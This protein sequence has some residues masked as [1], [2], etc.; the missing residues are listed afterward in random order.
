[1]QTAEGLLDI[2]ERCH[3]NLIGLLEHCTALS[4]DQLNQELPGFGYP[5]LRLQ[6]HHELGA[7][8]YWIGVLA[9]KMIIDD[10]EAL[11][12]TI[13]TLQSMRES[14]AATTVEYLRG[15][16]VEELNTPRTLLTWGN[17]ERSLQPAHVV[18]RTQMH[19]YHHQ[20]QVLAMC[21]LLGHP[22]SG[23]DYPISP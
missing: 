20:G 21:R 17:V 23:L 14:V 4:L 16:S 2:H 18:L 7:E 11:H 13:S 22:R 1:M 9:G 10:D 15:A 5:T 6:I 12:P 8:R 19:L 3:R